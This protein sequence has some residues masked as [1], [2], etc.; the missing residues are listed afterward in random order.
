MLARRSRFDREEESNLLLSA[1]TSESDL[2][3]I[4]FYEWVDPITGEGSGAFPFR[5]E[6][7]AV[8]VAIIDIFSDIRAKLSSTAEA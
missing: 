4:T 3:M 1:L 5:T 8:R 2:N 6:I 7:S